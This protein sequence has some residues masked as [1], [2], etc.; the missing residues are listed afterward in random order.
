[1]A[2][3]GEYRGPRVEAE[4]GPV[5][6]NGTATQEEPKPDGPAGG[7]DNTP[8]PSPP[9]GTVGYTLRITIHQATNLTMGDLHAFSS[10][11]YVL[12]QLNTN[13]PTRHKEDPNLRY[14]SRTVHKTTDPEWNAE[15]VVANIPSS[16]F[17]MKLRVY[18]EDC[19][20]HD[21]LLGKVHF[22]VS[23][24][25]DDWTGLKNTA[26]QLKLRNSSKRA[27]LFRGAARALQVVK[28]IHGS[29]HISIKNLGRT[30][31]DGQNGRPYTVAPCRWV[32]HYSPILGRMLNIKEPEKDD[33]QA[34]QTNGN[35]KPQKKVERY[36]FQAN[37]MQLPGP[38]PPQLYHRFVEFKPWV[39]RMFTTRGV[40]G[41]VLGKALHHQHVRV[42]NFDK[43]TVY[44][45]FDSA[46]STDMTKKFL[47]LVH[48]DKGGRIF[49]YVLTLDALFRFTETG[50]EFGIDMLSKHTMHSDVSIY[51]AFSGEFFIRRLKRRNRPKVN[52]ANSNQ[53][54]P[55][56]P[57]DSETHPPSNIDDGPPTSDPPTDPSRYELVIDNDSGTYRPSAA[58]LPT[59]RS[60]L[61]A[62]LPG[63]K[64]VTLDSQADAER[65]GKMKNEQRERKK[66]EGDNIVYAQVSDSDSSSSL[67]SSDDERLDDVQEAYRSEQRMAGRRKKGKGK[68][69]DR[70]VEG[71]G[72]GWVATVA[73]DVKQEQEARV[74]KLVRNAR[75]REKGGAGGWGGPKADAGH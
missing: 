75:G 58:L 47:E 71:G 50:K 4:K 1:M 48:Y 25:D 64:I 39:K 53:S 67:S 59:L 18:D 15:W 37:Q 45:L 43:S 6:R 60:Y 31:E 12:A 62:C 28:N 51:I 11:P 30:E 44:G 46:P 24:I 40:Q 38:V 36:N 52:G 72:D 23:S 13:L 57:S 17:K 21:D 33:D 34:P 70:A 8:I 56:P 22:T 2:T 65:M 66:A 68:G 14:R 41:V 20:D 54:L 19:A 61:E 32:R 55:T 35:G 73:R 29:L 5:A 3:N 49:T 7:F 9:A 69:S 63:L 42:Y 16:G 74:E 10:D 27:L 26:Y